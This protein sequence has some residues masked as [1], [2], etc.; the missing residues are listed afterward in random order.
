MKRV[1]VAGVMIALIAAGPANAADFPTKAP[2][3]TPLAPSWTGFYVGVNLGYSWNKD[4]INYV[5][6]PGTGF[7]VPPF[8][9]G[10]ALTPNLNS[11]SFL[12]GGQIGY[13][14]Q[15]GIW[16]FGIEAD[17]D[18]LANNGKVSTS[19]QINQF[20]D[21]IDLKG[22]PDWFGTVRGRVGVTLA[23]SWLVYG[24]GGLA[25]GGF[26]RMI[27]QRFANS[28][29]VFTPRGFGNSVTKFGWTAGAGIE[30]AWTSN[31]SVGVEYLYMDFGSDTSSAPATAGAFFPATT[32]TFHDTA[33]VVRAKLNFKL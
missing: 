12:G 29:T 31:W 1:A 13:N 30:Y 24:T 25:Y 16:V 8:A 19:I 17:A 22:Q 14:W 7:G 5:Q 2:A 11:H 10:L 33:H 15:A 28:P 32:T 23:P 21:T 18:L 4:A 26:D 27:T 20:P 9:A 6:G 3:L